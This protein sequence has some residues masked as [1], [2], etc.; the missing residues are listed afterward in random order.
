MTA[1]T[2]KMIDKGLLH[3]ETGEADIDVS[4]ADYTNY[5]ALLTIAPNAAHGV[6]DL[7]LVFDLAKATTGF[8]AGHTSQTLTFVVARKVDGTN[9]RRDAATVT[10][11]ISGTNSANTGG[12]AGAQGIFIGHVGPTEQVRVEVKMS[13]ENAV[14]VELPYVAYY[15]SGAS[16]TLT[17]VAA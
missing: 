12:L 14:D 6:R 1:S 4:A 15:E 17:A 10:T 7:R 8:A 13:A 3:V 2:K 5:Q 11:A 9:W 16:A